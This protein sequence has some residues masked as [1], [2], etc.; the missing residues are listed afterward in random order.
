MG[1]LYTI[2]YAMSG[3]PHSAWLGILIALRGRT[4]S[5]DRSHPGGS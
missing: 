5:D 4:G 3:T 1:A 2:L